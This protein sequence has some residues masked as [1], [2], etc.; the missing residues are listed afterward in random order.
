M[1][2]ILS[3]EMLSSNVVKLVVK[4]PQIAKKRKAGQFIMLK[5][6]E[7][8][9]RIPLT[10]ADADP[11]SGTVTIIAQVV[12]KTTKQL[13]TLNAGDTI[14]DFVGPLG[15]PTHIEKFGIVAC[16]GGGIGVAPMHPIAQALKTAGNNVISILGAR[17]KD[18]IIMEADMRKASNEVIIVTDDGSYGKKGFVTNALQDLVNSGTLPNLVVAIGPPI[19]MKM[20]SKLTE[21]MKIPTLVSLNTIMIDGTGMCG[22]CRVTVAGKTKFVCVDGPEFDGHQVDFDEM[23]NRLSFYK[24]EE[25]TSLEQHECK[26]NGVKK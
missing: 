18:L 24:E 6:D 25:K 23:M 7:T 12:G 14:L 10:I 2:K 15:K 1:N 16:I 5:I 22:G 4:A 9:E 17:N 21:S 19:M 11:A 26:L 20:V 8:G 13:A 3:K